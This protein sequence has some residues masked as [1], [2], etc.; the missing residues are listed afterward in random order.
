[1]ENERETPILL[2]PT[3]KS[4]VMPKI[5]TRI[6]LGQERRKRISHMIVL[7]V[8]EPR[9]LDISIAESGVKL[10]LLKNWSVIDGR[11]SQGGL[12]FIW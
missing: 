2:T 5:R 6:R 11:F 7:F 1:M 12:Y 8:A 3:R 9:I 4:V 10:F